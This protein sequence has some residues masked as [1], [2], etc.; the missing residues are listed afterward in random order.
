MEINVA[1]DQIRKRIAE[2]CDGRDYEGAA[3]A[4]LTDW[5]NRRA[6]KIEHRR[7]DQAVPELLERIQEV[8][9]FMENQLGESEMITVGSLQALE[10]NLASSATWL[11]EP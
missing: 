9:S 5:I 8:A 1:K 11:C 7:G 3:D 6:K 4:W 2:A 10:E